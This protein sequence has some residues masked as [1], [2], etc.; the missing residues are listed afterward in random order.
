MTSPY[1]LNLQLLIAQMGCVESKTKPKSKPK[2]VMPAPPSKLPAQRPPSVIPLVTQPPKT[3]PVT[4][5]PVPKPPSLIVVNPEDTVAQ[6]NKQSVIDKTDH[7]RPEP[8]P[9][10]PP[11]DHWPEDA[12]PVKNLESV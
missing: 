1:N 6:P 9:I 11:K 3:E 12:T 4:S 8:L 7:L 5:E 10:P 2:L